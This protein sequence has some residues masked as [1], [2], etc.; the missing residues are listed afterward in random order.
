MPDNGLDVFWYSFDYG[1]THIIMISTEH[2]FTIGT[3]LYTWLEQDLKSVNRSITPFLILAGHRPMY[4][5]ENCSDDTTAGD[6][7]VSLYMQQGF[8]DLLYKYKVDLA[9]WGHQH[10]YE[11]TCPV[12]KQKCVPDGITHIVV[13]TAGAELEDG[14]WN[15][16]TYKEWSAFH[17]VNWGYL[18]IS[19]SDELIQVQLLSNIDNSVVEEIT[20][21]KRM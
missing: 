5:S 20:L 1:N 21:K 2:N 4:T 11:R 15:M 13:G 3:P 17:W 12:Y 14:D 19:T 18:R 6:F 16:G 8:E 7:F 9:I 10:S